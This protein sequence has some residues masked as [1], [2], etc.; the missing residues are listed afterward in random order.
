MVRP[1][2]P[3]AFSQ[4]RSEPAAGKRRT[5]F[6]E[7]RL[8]LRRLR[9]VRQ[10]IL[11]RRGQQRMR[12][13]AGAPFGSQR[14]VWR[15]CETVERLFPGPARIGHDMS[16]QRVEIDFPGG[17]DASGVASGALGGRLA[18]FATEGKSWMRS[19]T[20]KGRLRKSS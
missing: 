3:G 12:G 8:T 13:R 9:A 20:E 5:Q 2:L 4:A 6:V 19:P 15:H 18:A 11:Q 14:Q 17:C 16:N 10:A 1:L 7:R